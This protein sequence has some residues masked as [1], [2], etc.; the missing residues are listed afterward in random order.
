MGIRDLSRRKGQRALEEWPTRRIG[1]LVASPTHLTTLGG[2]L[3]VFVRASTALLRT[4]ARKTPAYDV[5]LLTGGEA[6]L[7]MPAGI[8]LVGGRPWREAAEPIDTLLVFAG[9]QFKDVKFEPELLGWLREQA[10]RVRRIG[11]VCAGAFVLAAAGLLDGKQATTH[12]ELA[13]ALAR[14]YPKI[15]VD[16]D[17]IYTRDGNV[18]SSA[19]VSAGIDL[20]LAMVEEDFGHTVALD[21]A[22]RMV[23]FLQRSGGQRQFSTQLAAQASNHQPIRELVAWISENLDADLSVPALARRAAMS[24][25]NFS[26]VF[27]QQVNETPA[28]FVARLRTEAAQSKLIESRENIETIATDVG[29]GDGETLRRRLRSEVGASPLAFRTKAKRAMVPSVP[30]L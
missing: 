6:P 27:T 5:E 4:G 18:W 30:E 2:P 3:D 16:G 28:R 11:S 24:E 21:V 23:V 9:S 14:R 13:D 1:L 20:A 12:W 17:R 8:G 29:F 25:R 26:R 10:G 19:G 15:L 7:M 22:R